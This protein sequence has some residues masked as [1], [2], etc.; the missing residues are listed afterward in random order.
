MFGCALPLTLSADPCARDIELLC[1]F[2]CT[3]AYLHVPILRLIQVDKH[4]LIIL[5]DG[6]AIFEVYRFEDKQF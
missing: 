4:K 1:V 2:T 3:Y 5:E 6:I